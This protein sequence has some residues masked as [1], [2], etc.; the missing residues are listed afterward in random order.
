MGNPMMGGG[1][2]HINVFLKSFKAY[3]PAFFGKV[4]LNKGNKS[5][6]FSPKTDF[7]HIIR[8]IRDIYLQIII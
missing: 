7:V 3:S 6:F 1:G 8:I 5:K 4:E 2:S